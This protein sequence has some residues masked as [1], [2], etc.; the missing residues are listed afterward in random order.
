MWLIALVIDYLGPIA[1]G[2]AQSAWAHR[3]RHFAERHGLI[4]LITLGESIIAIGAGVG[5]LELDT[6]LVIAAALGIVVV[7]ALWWLYFDVAAIFA[8]RRLMEAGAVERERLAST[9]T[10]TCIC[11]WWPVSC[12][13][14]VG[15]EAT[16]HH[17]RWRLAT[18]PAVGL[19]GGTAL[20]LLAHR[21]RSSS[22]RPNGSSGAGRPPSSCCSA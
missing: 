2:L 20:Y 3:S 13:S 4:I 5:E 18:I 12:S 8:R 7:S 14:R 22:E 9:P 10:A 15:L 6:A 11:R 21:P 16:L 1:V 19:C 17:P